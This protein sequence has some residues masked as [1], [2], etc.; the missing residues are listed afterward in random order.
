MSDDLFGIVGT[1]QA[2]IFQVERF[3]AEGG[4]AVVYRAYHQGFRAP[5]ALKCLKVPDAM[6]PEQRAAFLEKFREEGELLFRLSALV[7]AV[8]RPLHVDVLSLDGRMVPF[9]ALEWLDG[10]GLDQIVATRR[11]Q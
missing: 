10:E 4:F 11:K 3:V 9:L 1:T 8:V 2:G 5:V 7:P 6:T